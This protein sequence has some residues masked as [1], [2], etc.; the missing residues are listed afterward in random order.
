MQIIRTQRSRWLS[1]Y[2][3]LS[4]L[5]L[6]LAIRVEVECRLQWHFR[7]ACRRPAA[8]QAW[9]VHTQLA[10]ASGL[11]VA[12]RERTGAGVGAR[13]REREG[14]QLPALPNENLIC[15]NRRVNKKKLNESSYREKLYTHTHTGRQHIYQHRHGR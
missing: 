13:G 5:E 15:V 11:S 6:E 1:L 3:S 14:M 12:P 9:Q 10:T 7:V 2:T 8:S 4:G